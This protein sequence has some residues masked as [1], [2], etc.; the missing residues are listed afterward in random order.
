MISEKL[1]VCCLSGPDDEKYASSVIQN[2][3]SAKGRASHSINQ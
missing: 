3:L 2:Y 1:P